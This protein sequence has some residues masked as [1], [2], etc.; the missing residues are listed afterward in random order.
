MIL[1]AH[2]TGNMFFRAA[3]R[4]FYSKGLL[5]ELH[6]SICWNSSSRVANLL[7]KGIATQLSRRSFNEI[8]LHLQHSYPLREYFRLISSQLNLPC[9][10]NHQIN[11]LSIDSLYQSFD[12]HIAK[13]LVS[14]SPLAGVYS[15]EDSAFF[16]FKKAHSLGLKCIYDLP[17][18]YWRAAQHVFAEERELVP[19]WA[20]TLTGLLDS[21]SK[22]ERKDV[23]LSL[24]HHVLVPSQFVAN[25]LADNSACSAPITIAPFGCP[26]V[27][28]LI[29]SI[30]SSGPLRVLY[31]G[32][33]GQRKGLS[34]AIN[35]VEE[36]KSMVTLTLIGRPTTNDC[37]PLNQAINRHRWIPTLAHS[38]ILAQMRNHDVLLLPSLFEG[39]A[40]VITEALSQG[41][42]VI[43]TPNTGANECID[44]N[45]EGFIVP[46]RDSLSIVEKLY[47]LAS[48]SNLLY[49]M[50]LSC[51]KRARIH[52][53]ASYEEI[54]LKA[55]IDALGS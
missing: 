11:F 1:L 3:A 28:S 43:A 7:P 19:E 14:I 27:T 4:A 33:L 50:R 32:S 36:L 38:E 41:L 22:L 26:N 24:A 39:F 29:P 16:T 23:E 17:I 47:Q 9:L 40:L 34:Y 21:Y 31:V 49:N 25:T 18:G 51:L 44:D 52:T 10:S 46:I 53:W 45:I 15:Y 35:A 55:S 2:P 13:S 30:R 12:K 48:D 8:P 5:A 37:I 20:S 42:P 6:S 54:I